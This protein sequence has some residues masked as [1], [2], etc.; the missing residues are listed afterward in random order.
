MLELSFYNKSDFDLKIASSGPLLVWFLVEMWSDK[1]LIL[2]FLGLIF[3]LAALCSALFT[4]SSCVLLTAYCAVLHC[5]TVYCTELHCSYVY[6]AVKHFSTAY[7]AVLHCRTAY[8]AV[9]H[10][11]SA[12]RTLYY[13]AAKI[14]WPCVRGI[15]QGELLNRA[16]ACGVGQV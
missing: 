12:L 4:A 9:L 15:S 8:S 10:C 6:Y 7:C 2:R 1:S 5:S 3:C 14:C 13:L 16:E 11:R